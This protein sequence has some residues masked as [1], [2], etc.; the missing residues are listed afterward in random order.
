MQQNRNGTLFVIYS[1][2]ALKIVIFKDLQ[3]RLN[4]LE[5]KQR[6]STHA[7]RTLHATPT[8]QSK[9]K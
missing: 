1:K 9:I 7:A 3:E 6:T 4:S 8:L 5:T 2:H